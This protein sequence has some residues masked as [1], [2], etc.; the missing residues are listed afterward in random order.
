MWLPVSPNYKN[1]NLDSERLLTRS[2]LKVFKKL[3]AA[4]KDASL[5]QGSYEPI[6]IGEDVLVYKRY[7]FRFVLT[8]FVI[9]YFIFFFQN[10]QQTERP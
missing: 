1:I 10:V 2:H 3:I 5:A 8:D 4:R 9:F 7:F 6:V